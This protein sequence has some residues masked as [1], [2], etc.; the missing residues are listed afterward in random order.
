M[1][2]AL[3]VLNAERVVARHLLLQK[4]STGNAESWILREFTQKKRQILRIERNVSIEVANDVV[5]QVLHPGVSSVEGVD[6]ASK[7]S[8]RA[9]GS[10]DQFDPVV[11][12]G[13][14]P[15]HVVGAV[16]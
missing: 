9:L 10:A 5:R 7:M 16:G 6:L 14:L 1:T 15:H 3:Y 2:R 8:F 11:V 4:G 12:N 13:I